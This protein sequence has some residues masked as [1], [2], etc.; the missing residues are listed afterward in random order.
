MAWREDIECGQK[1]DPGFFASLK[2]DT[3]KER[4]RMR[5]KSFAA[6]RVAQKTTSNRDE[7]PHLSYF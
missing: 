7:V 3:K 5:A 6:L 1:K 4:A 2:N